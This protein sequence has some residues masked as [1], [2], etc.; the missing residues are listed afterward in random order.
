MSTK[1]TIYKYIATFGFLNPLQKLLK[2]KTD[3]DSNTIISNTLAP[4]AFICEH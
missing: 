4:V 2:T 1:M 3:W